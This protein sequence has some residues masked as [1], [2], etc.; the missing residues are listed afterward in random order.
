MQ[1]IREI[2]VGEYKDFPIKR[3]RTIAN[4]RTI[5]NAEEYCN[6]HKWGSELRK[7]EGIIRVERL[8]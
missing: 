1:Q 2:R 4:Y 6:G 7:E 5:L 3:H 8:S